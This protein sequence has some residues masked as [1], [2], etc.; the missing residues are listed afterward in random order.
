MRKYHNTL[1]QLD[2]MRPIGDGTSREAYYARKSKLVFKVP[3]NERCNPQSENEERLFNSLP[4]PYKKVFPVVGFTEFQG[5]KVV[6]MRKVQTLYDLIGETDYET[7][8][9]EDIHTV[10][11]ICDE[12]NINR[13]SGFLFCRFVRKFGIRDLFEKNVGVYNGNLVIVDAGYIR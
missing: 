1:S 10:L 9:F 3:Y 12:L 13:S 11:R 5:K 6:V 4:E 2:K 8:D 7:E